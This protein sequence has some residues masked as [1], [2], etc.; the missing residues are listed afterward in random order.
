MS[1]IHENWVTHRHKYVFISHVICLPLAHVSDIHN[2]L[3]PSFFV[4]PLPSSHTCY[5]IVNR[6]HQ[7]SSACSDWS[8]HCGPLRDWLPQDHSGV[9]QAEEFKACLIS[10]GYDVETDKQVWAQQENKEFW[11]LPSVCVY[12]RRATH[13]FHHSLT[14][15]LTC[16]A[17]AWKDALCR[18]AKVFA[19]ILFLMFLTAS[20]LFSSVFFFF[21]LPLPYFPSISYP[22]SLQTLIPLSNPLL[23]SH[24]FV[25]NLFISPNSLL[26]TCFL[27]VSF[28][29]LPFANCRSARG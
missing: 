5:V 26:S 19:F 8:I 28:L 4:M 14:P 15:S 29:I 23:P 24:L 12:L 20:S 2:V 1:D 7:S 21:Y 25:Y 9:L 17:A 16:C 13:L 10:L 3:S 27:S 18:S 22:S 11:L 6:Y